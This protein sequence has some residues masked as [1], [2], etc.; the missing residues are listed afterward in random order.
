ML[1]HMEPLTVFEQRSNIL[2]DDLRM[3]S[4]AVLCRMK[5]D[6]KNGKSGTGKTT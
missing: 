3:T 5:R 1:G 4:V 2:K 6:L